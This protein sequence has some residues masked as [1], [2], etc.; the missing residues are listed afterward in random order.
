MY[1]DLI[2]QQWCEEHRLRGSDVKDEPAFY[3]NLERALDSRRLAHNL[4]SLKPRWDETVADFTS[5]DFL[6]LTRTGRLREA[7]L[8]ELALHPDF[9]LG[10]SGSRA[11]YGNYSYINQVEGE[12]A[13]FHGAET[14]FITPSTYA[15]NL[16]VLSSI[17]LPGDVIVYDELIHA[18]SH[19]GFRLS[20]AEQ[21]VPFSHNDPESL[22]EVLIRLKKDYPAIEAGTNSVLICVESIYSMDGDI[23]QLEDLVRTAEEVFPLGNAQFIMD[24]AHSI[25]VLGECG[26]GL[27]SMLGM[28]KSIAIR[29]HAVSKAIGALGGES[30]NIIIANIATIHCSSHETY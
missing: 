26:R 25:G 22:R 13:E 23:C 18:S 1:S 2:I 17:P 20:L 12:I 6:S 16:G 28:E 9:E 8:A 30:V 15:A 29:I 3:R 7:F 19:E 11:Q 24:E 5:A 10:A 4:V 21:T 27:V 14:A